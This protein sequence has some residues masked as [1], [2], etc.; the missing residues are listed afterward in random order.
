MAFANDSWGSVTLTGHPAER[1]VLPFRSTMPAYGQ[2]FVRRLIYAVDGDG[3]V[4][5]VWSGNPYS[6]QAFHDY[7]PA[8]GG[9]GT[10]APISNNPANDSIAPL[11][12][13]DSA[14]NAQLVWY[15]S[16]LSPR[17]DTGGSWEAPQLISSSGQVHSLAVDGL[18]NFHVFWMESDGAHFAYRRP[19][20]A[21]SAADDKWGGG[22]SLSG[23]AD[24]NGVA[25]WS[26]RKRG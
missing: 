16:G 6:S 14:G 10:D 24:A 19:G 2:I 5:V 3:N 1:G 7:L 26:G 21:V 4:H 9:W 11:I 8:G 20:R 23:A 22:N 25:S 18:G 13:T 12:V 15:K 17:T